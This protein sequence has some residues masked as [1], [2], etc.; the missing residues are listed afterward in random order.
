[1]IDEIKKDTELNKEKTEL[2]QENTS[3]A[4]STPINTESDIVDV[5]LGFVEKKRFR[6]AGD[7]NRMLELNVSDLNAL[8]R[9]KAGYPKLQ[10]LFEKAT[11]NISKLD[12]N[13]DDLEGLGIIAD[14]LESIDKDM[15]DII[16]SIFDANVSAVVAPSGNM[17]D[18]V[19][20]QYRFQR[21]IDIVSG[22]YSTGLNAEFEKMKNKVE[23]KTSKYTKKYHN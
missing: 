12:D 18:P 10:K 8:V 7:Y 2:E 5:D 13:M 4:V 19:G 11:T 22:L 1:M 16:D 9:L 20:G 21:V 3:P 14:T 15:R 23:K 6:I 17:F